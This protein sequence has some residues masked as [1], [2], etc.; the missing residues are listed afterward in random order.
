MGFSAS[1]VAQATVA[2]QIGAGLTSTFGSY[3]GASAQKRGLESQARVA[4]INA[5]IADLGAE[6][7]LLQG[8]SEIAKLTMQT[9]QLK[10]RQRVS[11]AA[12][13]I[14]LGV[15]NAA[16]IAAS[17]DLMKEIDIDTIKSNAA[18]TAW[19]YR[20]Q[21]MNLRTDAMVKRSTAKSIDPLGSA[22]SSLLSSASLVAS[23]WY[24]LQQEG[25][26]GATTDISTGQ[27]VNRW[28]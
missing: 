5:N 4:E 27:Q 2:T 22:A 28:W 1:Q 8:N 9:G 17:T 13:G 21:A 7:S 3:Y 25:A 14:D 23:S 12:N 20:S 6:S 10:A 15:G 19:G 18:R 11:M 26:F 16:E 24:G